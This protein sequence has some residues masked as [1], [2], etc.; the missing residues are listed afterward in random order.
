VATSIDPTVTGNTNRTQ[1]ENKVFYPALDGLRAIA[2]FMVFAQHYIHFPW[3]WSGVNAFF[4]LSGFLI[5][6]ILFDTRDDPH[7]TRNFYVRRT[8]RIFPLYYGIFLLLLITTPFFHWAWSAAWIAW[9]LYLG[10]FLRFLSPAASL[11]GTPLQIA[12]DANLQGSHFPAALYMGHFWS[13]CVEEQ[14]YLFWP[15]I[16]FFIRSRR[17]LLWICSTVVVLGPFARLLAQHLAPNWMLNA[18]LTYRLT[19]FQLDSLLLGALLALLWRGAHRQLLLKLGSFITAASSLLLLIYA[20]WIIAT[21]F[22]NFFLNF[23]YP[24][25]AQTWGLTLINVYSASLL[26]SALRP[27]TF[28]FHLFSLRPLRWVGRIS[29]GAYVIHDTLHMVFYHVVYRAA[30]HLHIDGAISYNTL[31]YFSAV[32]SLFGTLLI[33]YLSFRFFESPFLNLKERWTIRSAR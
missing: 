14:F 31:W 26:L 22:P 19:P 2:F 28:V 1:P 23:H 8:L 21:C 18:E 16:I 10:N 33:A 20:A 6:G 25:W 7:R 30:Q 13:L 11:A 24:P 12:A 9:P 29:Y 15:W 4:V 27:G 5:T 17:T 32:F 3:G